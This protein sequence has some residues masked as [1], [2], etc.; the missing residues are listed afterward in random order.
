MKPT[1]SAPNCTPTKACSTRAWPAGSSPAGH[2]TVNHHQGEYARGDV[3]TNHVEGF[4]SQLKRSIDGTHHHVSVEQLQ[5]Y[6]SKFA[7]RYSYRKE[8]DTQR[9]TRIFG[10]T[11]G[12]SLI[13][14]D[15]GL[16]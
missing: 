15:F 8:S 10:Q 13:Y 12:R 14:R 9:M 5:R 16:A 11:G 1:R 2:E 4:F 7:F 3:T 6:V